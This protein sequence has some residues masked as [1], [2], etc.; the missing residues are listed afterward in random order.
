MPCHWL[1]CVTSVC[2]I[3]YIDAYVGITNSQFRFS[4]RYFI[5]RD[6]V[7]NWTYNVLNCSLRYNTSVE[8]I[9]KSEFCPCIT[10]KYVSRPTSINNLH[11]VT[12]LTELLQCRDGTLNLTDNNVCFSDTLAM[13]DRLC[14]R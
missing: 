3:L 12:L 5:R 2:L 7:Y 4:P 14:T 11:T 1:S 9:S 6:G 8:C 13:M 10:D